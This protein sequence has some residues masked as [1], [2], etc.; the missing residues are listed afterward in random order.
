VGSKAGKGPV[1]EEKYNNFKMLA[2]SDPAAMPFKN[3]KTR[4]DMNNRN[5]T[6][7]SVTFL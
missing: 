7:F 4:F 1:L 5:Q 6:N 2:W 3:K